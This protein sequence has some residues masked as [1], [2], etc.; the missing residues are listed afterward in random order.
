[1]QGQYWELYGILENMICKE[2]LVTRN[3]KARH[4]NGYI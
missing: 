3:L 1:M 4:I 2:K